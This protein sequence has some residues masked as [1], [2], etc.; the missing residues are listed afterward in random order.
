MDRGAPQ[1]PLVTRWQGLAELTPALR[2]FVDRSPVDL[3]LRERAAWVCYAS[4]YGTTDS[5]ELA[6]RIDPSD[7]DT[8]HYVQSRINLAALAILS[9]CQPPTWWCRPS[10]SACVHATDL[11]SIPSEP[12]RLL[13][14]PGIVEARR[15]ETGERLW[16][17]YVSLGWYAIDGALYILGL[18]YP[19][20][21]ALARWVPRWT[22]ED[23]EP[24][25]PQVD[26]SPLI[27][28]VDQHHEFARQAA[29][30]LIVLGLLAEADP[31]PLRIEL[32]KRERATRHVYLG[33]SAPTPRDPAVADEIEGRVAEVVQVRG[34]LKRQRYGAGR[35]Q[36]KWIYV[37]SYEARRWFAPRWTVERKEPS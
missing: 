28:D 33:E 15:P 11:H 19:D 2:R 1:G 37:P 25:L 21:Y 7:P 12:P 3:P 17:D 32:D 29:R 6:R 24:E 10:A 27:D 22:G 35:E 16:A 26:H 14:E 30:Y 4:L 8:A 23:L 34:H 5:D 20:G 36:V 18:R 31:S 9:R 13:R